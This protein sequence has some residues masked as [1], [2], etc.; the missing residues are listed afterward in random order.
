MKSN[1]KSMQLGIA[2]VLACL[3]IA[4]LL[5]GCGTESDESLILPTTSTEVSDEIIAAPPGF[6]DFNDETYRITV[7]LIYFEPGNQQ[8]PPTDAEFAEYHRHI[9]QIVNQAQR[10]FA[11]E[12]ERHGY[13]RKSFHVERDANNQVKLLRIKG[14]HPLEKYLDGGF[15]V[16][17]SEQVDISNARSDLGGGNIEVWFLDLP[18]F[19][20]CGWG[21]G[22]DWWGE[23]FLVAGRCWDWQTLAHEL[24]HTMGLSHDFRDEAYMMSYGRDRTEL[25]AGAAKW[26][27][28]HRAFQEGRPII[29][30]FSLTEIRVSLRKKKKLGGNNYRLSFELRIPYN[31]K[32]KWG[33]EYS[34]HLI[35]VHAVLEQMNSGMRGGDKVLAWSSVESKISS[36]RIMTQ[37][38]PKVTNEVVNTT[39]FRVS[40]PEETTHVGIE[41]MSRNG[42]ILNPLQET[43]RFA[44][45]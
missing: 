5:T 20:G 31:P 41:M 40:I 7:R 2:F 37:Y 39:T 44:I 16:F 18:G 10:F 15:G 43:N 27:N 23:A 14:E 42:Q 38:G 33:H 1:I 45:K 4:A 26:L 29:S 19:G 9:N 8:F 13:G 11:G 35:P 30:F 25:S 36:G 34:K 12:M 17:E 22:H 3:C 28:Y 21:G 32:G 24:G 6:P